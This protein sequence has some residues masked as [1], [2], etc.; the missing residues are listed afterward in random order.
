METDRPASS[1][2]AA[3]T[4]EL[5]TELDAILLEL[6]RRLDAYTESGRDDVVA[7]D[8]GFRLAGLVYASADAAARH[9]D[10]VRESLERAHRPTQGA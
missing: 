8:E 9:A 2:A 5:L 4:A 7:A 3:N 6:R 1:L 10:E